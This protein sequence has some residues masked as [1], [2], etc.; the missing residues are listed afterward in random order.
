MYR[1]FTTPRDDY[2]RISGYLRGD[3]EAV[4][5]LRRLKGDEYVTYENN[6]TYGWKEQKVEGWVE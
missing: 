3:S 2:S 5:R 1:F 4:R 6:T